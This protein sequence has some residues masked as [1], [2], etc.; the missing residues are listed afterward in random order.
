MISIG[1]IVDRFVSTFKQKM[2]DLCHDFNFSQ[3]N[4]ELVEKMTSNLSEAAC[5]GPVKV[6]RTS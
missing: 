2:V 6:V 4:A 5:V 1:R 3:L